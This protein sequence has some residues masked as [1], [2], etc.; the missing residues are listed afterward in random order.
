MQGGISGNGYLSF[1]SKCVSNPVSCAAPGEC[2]PHHSSP[3]T[4][5]FF[6]SLTQV[7]GVGMECGGVCDSPS[8]NEALQVKRPLF[9]FCA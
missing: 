2:D 6:S 1:V 9:T 5:Q 8:F 7:S 4:P 3:V